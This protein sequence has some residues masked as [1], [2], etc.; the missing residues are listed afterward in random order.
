MIEN[1]SEEPLAH[2]SIL[3]S[4]ELASAVISCYDQPFKQTLTHQNIVARAYKIVVNSRRLKT[5]NTLWTVC[6]IVKLSDYPFPKL[7]HL[8]IKDK[9]ITL[10][11]LLIVYQIVV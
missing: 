7:I 3:K 11:L 8:I 2:K 1:N 6:R 9:T 5:L 4:L 10:Y